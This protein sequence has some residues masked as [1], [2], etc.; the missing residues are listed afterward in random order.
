MK[1]L[2]FHSLALMIL[3]LTACNSNNGTKGV[4]Q[5]ESS[6]ESS[7]QA[8]SGAGTSLVKF[9]ENYEKGVLYTTVTRG[10]TYEELYTSREAIEAVQSGE[11][12]PSGTVITLE[13]YQDEE[14]DR[15]FVME[16][17]NGWAD[18][19][20]ADMRNGH[21]QYQEF[22][23]DGSVNEEADIGRCFSCHANQERDDYVNTL[24]EMQDFDLDNIAGFNEGNTESQIAGIPIEEWEV[25]EVGNNLNAQK[26]EY[27]LLADMSKEEM[28]QKALFMIHFNKENS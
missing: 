25:K 18:Q 17:R 1:R 3:I 6:D 5:Q 26:D 22:T 20:P 16:K 10:N 27:E 11:P 14:L 4:S 23:E 24:D 15:I 13:I 8:S 28:I 7:E 19:N 2:I 9:P 12:I 21:W